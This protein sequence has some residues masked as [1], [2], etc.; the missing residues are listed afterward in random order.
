[1]KKILDTC[2]NTEDVPNAQ[3]V[4]TIENQMDLPKAILIHFLTKIVTDSSLA[5][6][7]MFYSAEL[8]ELAFSNLRSPHWQIRYYAKSI[9]LY[10][11]NFYNKLFLVGPS[12]KTNQLLTV[13]LI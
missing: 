7:M 5:S 12:T 9:M 6:D 13:S 1:M 4:A 3:D 11:I 2:K 10:I 8:A